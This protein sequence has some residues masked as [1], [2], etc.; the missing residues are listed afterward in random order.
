MSSSKSARASGPS[1]ELRARYDELVR[2]IQRHD[3]LYHALDQPEISDHNYDLLVEEL[4]KIEAAHPDWVRADSPSQRVGSQP[5]EAFTK[6]AHRRPMLSLQN[7]YSVEDID[8]FDARVRKQLGSDAPEVIEYFCEPKFDGLAMELIYE[9]GVLT[10]ALTRGDGAVGEDVTANIRTIRSVPLRLPAEAPPLFEVRGEVI[11][12]KDDFRRLNEQQEADGE[13]TFANPRNAAA[14]SIRQLDS[15]IA[16]SRPLRMFI[17]APGVIEGRS[18]ASQAEFEKQCLAWGLPGVGV[19]D[20]STEGAGAFE[21]RLQVNKLWADSLGPSSKFLQRLRLARTARGPAEARAYYEFIQSIRESLPFDIDGVVIKVNSWRT[22]DELGFVA[23]SPRWATAAKFPP[24]Q[25]ETTLREIAVQ[26]GRTGA[27]TPVAILEPARVGG[28]TVSHATLHNQ[29]EIDRKDLRVGD[30]VI[31]QRAGD[32]IPEVVRVANPD[33]QGRGPKFRL[34]THCPSCG[35]SVERPE[36]EAVARCVNPLCPAIVKESIKHFV[37]R[38]AMNIEGLG[39]KLIEALVDEKLIARPSDLYFLKLEQ[40]LNLERQGEKSAQKLIDAIDRSRDSDLARVIYALGIRFVG[41]T[42]AKSLALAFGDHEEFLAATSEQ[43]S[44]IPDVG[45]KVAQSLIQA[46]QGDYVQNE[47]R[48]LQEGGVRLA[49]RKQ[50]TGLGRLKG[51][52]FVI[53]GTLPEPR[54]QIKALIESEGGLVQG[55]VSKKTDIL[56]A[57]E[58]AGSKLAKAEELGIRVVDWAEFQSLLSERKA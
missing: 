23:R 54:D 37:S 41:E 15:R 33:D 13:A 4:L 50:A 31:I 22:Q 32:V 48:R 53:T 9:Q 29:D 57:G 55:S 16:A 38:R 5:L 46:L 12:L 10:R 58:E 40:V 17:Y 45:E 36:G 35:N 21:T 24:Q 51:V 14:G 49:K 42:T 44:A 20:E 47:V 18:F 28:V 7:S 56:L 26:V 34:P 11:L 1:S 2:E 6:V 30:R 8:E 39:D 27:L 19:S 43:L 3:H 25:A 52:K